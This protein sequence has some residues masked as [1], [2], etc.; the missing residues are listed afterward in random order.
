MK[1]K[2][3]KGEKGGRKEEGVGSEGG[4]GVWKEGGEGEKE[5]R[6]RRRKSEEEEEYGLRR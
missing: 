5:G 6:E 4:E 2:K 3:G 1:R